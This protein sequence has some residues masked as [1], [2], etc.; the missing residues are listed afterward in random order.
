MWC[1]CSARKKPLHYQDTFSSFYAVIDFVVLLMNR[2]PRFNAN[3]KGLLLSNQE[4]AL[5]FRVE[6]VVHK[7]NVKAVEET[8]KNNPH[9]GTGKLLT[10]TIAGTDAERLACLSLVACCPIRSIF[11]WEPTL[12]CE[13]LRIGKVLRRVKR[14]KNRN[15]DG[16]LGGLSLCMWLEY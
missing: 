1:Y 7:L 13:A 5:P 9:L 6:I 11:F 2:L 16:D 8:C 3:P 14:C 4:D 15:A 10:Q 12:W